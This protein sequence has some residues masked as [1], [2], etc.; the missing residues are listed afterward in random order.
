MRE[1][2]LKYIVDEKG[3]RIAVVIPI[4]EFER[5][6]EKLEDLDDLRVCSERMNEEGVSLEEFESELRRDGII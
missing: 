5:L 2:E 4:K 3:K 6:M 1:I